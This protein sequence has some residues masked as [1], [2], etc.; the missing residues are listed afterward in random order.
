LGGLLE[1]RCDLLGQPLHRLPRVTGLYCG[2]EQHVH[3]YPDRRA[4]Q[5]LHHPAESGHLRP[6]GEPDTQH[7]HCADWH[8]NQVRA[9]SQQ[10]AHDDGH[11]HQDE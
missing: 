1:Q 3:Q 7:Q 2:R 5:R 11:G 4:D 9:K 8:L 10:L 6:C